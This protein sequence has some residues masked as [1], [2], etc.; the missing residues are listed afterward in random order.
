MGVSLE[1]MMGTVSKELNTQQTALPTSAVTLDT[2]MGGAPTPA[3]EADEGFFKRS[4]RAI[5]DW[6]GGAMRDPVS[7]VTGLAKGVTA[8]AIDLFRLADVGLS[9]LARTAVQLS[10]APAQ[11]A[12]KPGS[13]KLTPYE[14]Y[15]KSKSAQERFIEA[16]KKFSEGILY[17]NLAPKDKQEEAVSRL[18]G[19]LPDAVIAT[20]D[21]V[22][23]KTGSALAGAGSQALLTLVTLKPSV[24]SKALGGLKSLKSGEA[25]PGAKVGATKVKNAFEE[26]AVKDQPAA[27]AMKAHVEKADPEL[28]ALLEEAI[29]EAKAKTPEQVGEAAAKSSLEGPGLKLTD[30]PID[31][32]FEANAPHQ[33]KGTSYRVSPLTEETFKKVNLP[34]KMT[35]DEY[36]AEVSKSGNQAQVPEYIVEVTGGDKGIKRGL[37][38]VGSKAQIEAYFNEPS[39]KGYW[40]PKGMEEASKP[41]GKRTPAE[42]NK[43]LADT[44]REIAQSPDQIASKISET[45]FE[46]TD[47]FQKPDVV[48]D[49]ATRETAR[50]SAN[51]AQADALLKEELKNLEH[52]ADEATGSHTVKGPGSELHAQEN[53]KYLQVKRTDVAEPLRGKGVNRAMMEKL[54]EVAAE[55]DL[56]VASDITVSKAAQRTYESLKKK[57]YVVK[58]NPS[59]INAE[60]GSKISRDPRLPVYEVYK[61]PS[62][63][64]RASMKQPDP[65]AYVD[66]GHPVTRS[67]VETAF[68]LGERALDSLPGIGIVKGKLTE[69]YRQLIKTI[70]PEAIGPESKTAASILAKHIAIQMQKDSAFYHRAAERRS[71]WSHNPEL[72]TVFIRGFEKGEKFSD[73]LLAKAAEGYRQWNERVYQS[74]KKLGLK[75]EPIDNY[76]YHLFEDGPALT[77]FLEQRFG[78]RWGDPG[79]IKDRGFD[80]YEEAVAAGYKPK[81][82]NPEDIMLARQHASDV[83]QLRVDTLREMQRA[84]LATKAKPGGQRPKDF[85][86]QDWRSPNGEHYWVHDSAGAILDNAWNTQSLWNMNG[87]AG[88]TFRGA[89]ALKNTI[90]PIKLALSLFHPLHVLTID[91][92]TG[93]VRASKELLSG[94][95]SP[96]SWMK[97]MAQATFYKGFIDS[98]RSGYR[99]LKAYQ[100][101]IP[102][103][104]MSAADTQALTYM[105]EGGFIPEMST[106]Y[107]T[108]AVK[109]FKDAIARRSITS[110]FHAPLAAISLTQK[111]MFEIWIPSLKIASYLKDVKTAVTVDPS[112]LENPTR[113]QVTFRKIAKSV[114]NRYGEM[115]YNTLFWNRWVKD[116]AVANTLSLGWQMGF[117]REYGGGMMDLGQTV[118]KQ[119]SVV[120]KAQRGMLDRPLFVTFYTTQALAYGGLLTWALSGQEPQE[121]NDYVY[122]LSGELTTEGKP[123]RLNT[124]FYPREFSAI[125]K[126]MENEGVVSGLGHLAANKA[127]GVVGMTREWATG[128]NSFG[129]E[130]RDPDAPAYK[131][132]A[133]TLAYTLTDLEPISIGA[134]RDQVSEN[135]IKSAALNIAGFSPAPRYVTETKTEGLIR[136]TFRKYYSQK[137]TPFERAEYSAEAKKLR[138]A[139]EKGDGETYGEIIDKLQE[140]FDLTGAEQRRLEVNIMRG[141]EPLFTMF[142]R[143]TWKQQKKILDQMGEE[144]REQYL[145]HSNRQHLRYSYEPPEEFN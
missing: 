90:V 134:I 45:T 100:G 72:A 91:N 25:T 86:G 116:L 13:S 5:V 78:K 132:L 118:T 119:G 138:Q 41:S 121:L 2:M 27:E 105:A 58:E 23:E 114:D 26:L 113:R 48:L 64:S 55:R 77:Q 102:D 94:T 71:Y 67:S 15:E 95:K 73:P 130:I 53:G 140:K 117:I 29:K 75:Y 99:L 20:G 110:V 92:A 51:K 66:A 24:A 42:R 128:V 109:S 76:L 61:K 8:G 9:T 83:A 111:P 46:A 124:M 12:R 18:L 35:L 126:H 81:F 36:K 6:Y 115:A 144:E 28:G 38:M 129:Q 69:Y 21:T 120:Q 40:S 16:D 43:I 3:D 101:R 11:E 56:T 85:P 84:G 32:Q 34:R 17:V 49:K 10:E 57:G 44:A 88:D 70:N 106:Q 52:V 104:E 133:Q 135:P 74:D 87:I 14:N 19:V 79:F 50:Q 89:M 141:S 1:E 39:R 139:Y 122:P 54:V 107:K 68:R 80:L 60:T 137:Q 93:M 103:A 123:E 82:T 125:Y 65:I 136:G 31:I 30:Q 47:I 97:E 142:E 112:L 96:A 7:N 33:T 37:A 98:P 63:W 145:P 131:Q 59:T 143:L 22:Y 127:S 4:G 62:G 108:S